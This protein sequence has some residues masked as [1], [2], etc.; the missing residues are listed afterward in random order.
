LNE[1]HDETVVNCPDCEI[2][3]K[4]PAISLLTPSYIPSPTD[5]STSE[6]VKLNYMSRYACTRVSPLVCPN[7]TLI[8]ELGILRLSRELEGKDLNALAYARAISVR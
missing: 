3:T 5:L 8:I 7:Q 4:S 2:S 6:K 1:L